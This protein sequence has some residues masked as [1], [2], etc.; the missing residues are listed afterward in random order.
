MG[1]INKLTARQVAALSKPG[2]YSDGGNLYLEIRREGSKSWAFRYM[3]AGR[4]RELGLGPLNTVSLQEA[5][6]RAMEAR[7]CL[8]EGKDP[9][10][11]KREARTAAAIERLKTMTFAEA[12]NEF[13]RT[14]RPIARL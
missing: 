11:V 4:A 2:R 10:E 9:I 14:S 5:R 1:G 8:I 12:A 6:N 7:R 3:I 13:L